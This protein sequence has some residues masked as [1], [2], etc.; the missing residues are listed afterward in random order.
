MGL[1]RT[2]A[3][4]RYGLLRSMFCSK[5]YLTQ[6]ELDVVYKRLRLKYGREVSF[7]RTND[8]YQLFINYISL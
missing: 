1:L 3:L 7:V 2:G 6:R 5:K 8:L 4:A